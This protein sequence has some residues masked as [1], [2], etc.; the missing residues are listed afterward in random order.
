[1]TEAFFRARL[2]EINLHHMVLVFRIGR[3][4]QENKKDEDRFHALI[5][6]A[7]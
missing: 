2:L 7:D 3:D 5:I 6:D 4:I 1:V